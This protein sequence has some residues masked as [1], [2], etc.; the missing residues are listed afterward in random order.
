VKRSALALLCCLLLT[1]PVA[2]GG[3]QQP[4]IAL[5]IDDLGDH[6]AQG[7]RSIALQGPVAVAVIPGT[8][9]G[10]MLA[11]AARDNGKEVLVHMPMQAINGADPGPGALTLDMDEQQ[12]VGALAAALQQVPGA[13]GLN[14]HMGSLITRHPG[15]MTWVMD[16]LG[17][18]TP[19]L[20]FIDSRTTAATVAAGI[21]RDRGIAHSQRDVFL[22]HSRDPAHMEREFRRLIGLAKRNGSAV[23]I[24]HPYPETLELLER[25]LPGLEEQ[26]GVRLVPLTAVLRQSPEQGSGR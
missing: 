7:L 18:L 1:M 22:D 19:A 20:F 10:R 12:V 24:G 9:H 4:V 6:R 21:A 11:R 13:T 8:A 5:I 17:S 25:K 3:Q 2:G 23:G 26:H 14:N 15:H 16:W